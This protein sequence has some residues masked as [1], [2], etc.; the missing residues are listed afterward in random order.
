VDGESFDVSIASTSG[1]N[2]EALDTSDTATV[3]VSDTTNIVTATL[4]TV[5]S[6]ISGDDGGSIEYIITLS[7]T[8]GDIDPD[9]D[10]VFTLAN[11]EEITIV[12]GAI[13]GSVT[14]T[15]SDADLSTQTAIT[16][17]IVSVKS[18]GSE[19]EE[20]ETAGTTNVDVDYDP[21]VG[22]AKGFGFE[23]SSDI[24][25]TLS[26][27]DIDGTIS[28]FVIETL[29]E[30]GTLYFDGNEIT[31]VG[32]VVMATGNTAVLSFVPDT[33]WS[34]D[35]S[36][37]FHAVDDG[38]AE[39]DSATA[40]VTVLPVTDV[41]LI[42]IS[43]GEVSNNAV[44]TVINKDNVTDSEQGYIVT[45]YDINGQQATLSTVYTQKGNVQGFGVSG[46]AGKS[47]A[48]SELQQVNGVSEKIV[49]DFEQP[50]SELSVSFSWLSKVEHAKYVVKDVHGNVIGEGII[51][52]VTD[53]VDSAIAVDGELIG[54]IEFTAPGAA[55]GGSYHDDYLIHQITYTTAESYPVT[56]TAQATDT[57]LSEDITALSV[58]IPE[59]TVLSHGTLI[60]TENGESTWS[61][62]L[63]S[64]EG[65]SYNYDAATDT[66][67]VTGLTVTVPSDF[68]GSLNVSATVTTQDGSAAPASATDSDEVSVVPDAY[69]LNGSIVTNTNSSD[70]PIRLT[71]TDLANPA[72]TF[73]TIIVLNTEGQQEISFRVNTGFEIDPSNQYL[74]SVNTIDA[75]Q[76]VQFTS[77]TVEG[78]QLDSAAGN[79]QLGYNNTGD[80]F[81][82]MIQPDTGAADTS[83][84]YSSESVLAS[85]GPTTAA[86]QAG[87]D[88]PML[89][90]TSGDDTLTGD[91]GINV[92]SG[93]GGDDTLSGE[94]GNDILI[95]GLGNDILSGGADNDVLYG[96]EGNDT[97]TGGTGADTFIWNNADQGTSGSPALDVVTDFNTSE[98]DVLDISDLLQGEETNDLTNYL[99][100]SESGSDV[101]I[102]ITP[103]GSG[104]VTQSI[105]LENISLSDLGSSA[106]ATQAEIINTLIDGGYLNVD[107]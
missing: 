82:Q 12:A 22:L 103:S 3:T 20:L 92:L 94:G 13:S 8:P 105:T 44:T 79:I 96:N 107:S 86:A 28:S 84:D 100:V 49:V 73:S 60:S 89:D 80:G 26:G 7:G 54:S 25:V 19:Y 18:G 11:G 93:D 34:G 6:D 99:S 101:V 59:G 45:A 30:H 67:E 36:F 68:S 24:P 1:G 58:T 56:I 66:V 77:F 2:Y 43:L 31:S 4:T 15:Y 48:A 51:E 71:F 98:G 62:P 41:P 106:T 32:T 39:S 10:L 50:V 104:D 5:T 76:K 16:N 65:Y 87:T 64:E 91:D 74:V 37:A 88:V 61:L 9:T 47:G 53:K 40:D 57:D 90:G 72:N 102:D 27:T 69:Y 38:G 83:V 97:L 52:G 70:Q 85:T 46:D 33:D 78:V 21:T 42:S 14:S 29:P 81:T 35:T 55:N 95:G 75:G 63:S 17:S 23:D